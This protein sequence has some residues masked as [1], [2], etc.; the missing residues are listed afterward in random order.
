MTETE[1]S[2]SAAANDELATRDERRTAQDLV[3][4]IA[5]PLC[6]APG[7]SARL[8][9][10]YGQAEPLD[11]IHPDA[12]PVAGVLCQGCM[13]SVRRQPCKQ[14]LEQLR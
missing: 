12:Y 3:R 2:A 5:G 14:A 7:F 4:R 10:G 13:S 6:D 9:L 11:R 8:C 1:H